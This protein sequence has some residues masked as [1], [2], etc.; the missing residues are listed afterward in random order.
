MTD[1]DA[2][3]ARTALAVA[4]LDVHEQFAPIIDCADGMRADLER[5]GWSPT[6]AEH[7]AL[8]WLCGALGYA[9]KASA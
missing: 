7:V 4:M 9:W 2:A 1:A 8:T 5:R 3:T 6:A